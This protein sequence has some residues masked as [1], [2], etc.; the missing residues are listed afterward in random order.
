M[1]DD[2]A[3]R[4]YFDLGVLSP[5]A[6]SGSHCLWSFDRAKLREVTH[7]G[8]SQFSQERV[9]YVRVFSFVSALNRVSF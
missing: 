6:L 5:R 7:R 3:I 9:P 1:D 4:Q 8:S 2:E